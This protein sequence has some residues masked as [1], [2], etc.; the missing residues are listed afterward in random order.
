[1]PLEDIRN[2]KTMSPITA[3]PSRPAVGETLKQKIGSRSG[4]QTADTKN[5]GV[6]PVEAG[7][8]VF[9]RDTELTSYH[10]SSATLSIATPCCRKVP[11]FAGGT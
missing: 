2:S 5:P 11:R 10:T 9:D 1:M 3:S 8:H 4:R 7:R 6:W